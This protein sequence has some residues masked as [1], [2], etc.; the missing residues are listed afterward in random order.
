MRLFKLLT[1][2]LLVLGT[3]NSCTYEDGPQLSLRSKKSRLMGKWLVESPEEYSSRS[4]FFEFKDDNKM[5]IGYNARLNGVLQMMTFDQEWE[6]LDDKKQVRYFNDRRDEVWTI[7]RL[8]NSEF[9]F[10]S[11]EDDYLYKCRKEGK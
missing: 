1:L 8:T 7:R 6:W 3:L 4:T 5:I 2:T 9:W 10:L 11:D